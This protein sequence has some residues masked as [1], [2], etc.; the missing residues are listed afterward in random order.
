[1][2]I[3][4]Q[5]DGNRLTEVDIVYPISLG[6]VVGDEFQFERLLYPCIEQILMYGEALDNVV[7]PS[8]DFD[9]VVFRHRVQLEIRLEVSDVLFEVVEGGVAVLLHL[10]QPDL[11]VAR[12]RCEL[13]GDVDAVG[14]GV[15]AA[16]FVFFVIP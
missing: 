4:D 9:A 11:L 13:R 3:G 5:R 15:V 12:R 16:L 10:H 8:A 1:M 7:Y 2:G 14:E 6:L